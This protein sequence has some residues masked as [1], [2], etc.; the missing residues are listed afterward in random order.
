[1]ILFQDDYEEDDNKD[2]NDGDDAD[3]NMAKRSFGLII[4][5]YTARSPG[6]I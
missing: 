2:D 4:F 1:M 6:N 5:A 3:E